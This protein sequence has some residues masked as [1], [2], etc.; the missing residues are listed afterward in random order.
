MSSVKSI[1]TRLQS[2][3]DRLVSDGST[4]EEAVRSGVWVAGTN[5]TGR[6]FQLAKV[7]ILARLLSPTAFGLLGIGL[8]VTVA[9]KNFSRIGLDSSLIYHRDDNVDS[10]LDTAWVVKLTRGAVIAGVAFVAAPQLAAFFNEPRAIHIIQVVAALTF[11]HSIQN[12]G[13]VYFQKNLNFHREFVYQVAPAIADLIIA[14]CIALVTESVW[15]LVAGL[16]AQNILRVGLSYG[17]H[18]Y[19]PSLSFDYNKFMEMIG[20]GKWIFLSS[21]LV[22]LYSQGDDAF[23]GW[24]FPAAALGF[25]QVS[26]RFSNAPATEISQV[27]VQVAFPAFSKIQDDITRLRS[28]YYRVMQLTAVVGFPIAAGII[29]VSPQFVVAVL[30]PEWKQAISLIQVLAVWGVL[31]A[32]GKPGGAVFKATGNPK[33]EAYLQAITATGIIITILP[34][35]EKFGLVGVAYAIVGVIIITY[36]VA[37][38]ITLSL[39]EGTFRELGAIISCPL[40]TSIIMFL[41]VFTLDYLII[42]GNGLINLFVLIIFGIIEYVSISLIIE[43]FT[44]YKFLSLFKE[45]FNNI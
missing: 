24:Y 36:P 20:F 19:R 9:L 44:D 27:I 17:I 38:Y 35:A 3:Y 29:A 4:K 39:I 10:Y 40:T 2:V 37:I 14:V 34:A 43:S 23:I 5:V 42:S 8:L 30:G 31:R 41:S 16:L 13:V 22:F 28:G 11:L 32:L 7:I 1:V 33:Y 15:A 12:P 25:Y 21:I 45:L 26:Y 6:I 18:E